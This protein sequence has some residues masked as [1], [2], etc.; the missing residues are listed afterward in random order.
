MKICN[1][2]V[3]RVGDSYCARCGEPI[4][5]RPASTK[6]PMVPSD[7]LPAGPEMCGPAKVYACPA[8]GATRPCGCPLEKSL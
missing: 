8:C 6:K 3:A 2:D 5:W 4:T 7:T 1:H